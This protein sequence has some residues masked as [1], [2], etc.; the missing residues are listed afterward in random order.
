MVEKIMVSNL[1]PNSLQYAKF[2]G[3]DY[4][5]CDGAVTHTIIRLQQNIYNIDI[6]IPHDGGETFLMI[7]DGQED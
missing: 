3:Q 7:D 1:L 6:M 5:Y 4:A 2:V